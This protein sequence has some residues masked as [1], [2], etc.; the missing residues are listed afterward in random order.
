MIHYT[1]DPKIHTGDRAMAV[2]MAWDGMRRRLG[3][4][5]FTLLNVSEA[6]PTQSELHGVPK[7]PPRAAGES[8]DAHAKRIAAERRARL[9]KLADE[10]QAAQSRSVWDQ[11][12]DFT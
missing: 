12:D 1:T 7:V 6:T 8:A 4:R 11:L 9:A 10:L 2:Y 3:E 5:G